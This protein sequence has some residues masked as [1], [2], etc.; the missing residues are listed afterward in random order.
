VA[1]VEAE[2]VIA[3]VPTAATAAIAGEQALQAKP[4][5]A[6]NRVSPRSESG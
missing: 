4:D 6:L 3:V 1:V 2:A 5:P